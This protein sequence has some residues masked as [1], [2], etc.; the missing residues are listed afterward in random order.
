MI[1]YSIIIPVFNIENHIDKTLDS[2]LSIPDNT[3]III[4]NDG[5]TDNTWKNV[6]K[7]V[8]G[9]DLRDIHDYDL[10]II[11]YAQ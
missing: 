10:S 11:R 8:A 1:K 7:Y 6:E 3:E 2:L 4:V 9:H 5:S